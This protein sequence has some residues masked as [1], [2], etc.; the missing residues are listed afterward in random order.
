MPILS[1]S[2]CHEMF[3]LYT[4]TRHQRFVAHCVDIFVS[5]MIDAVPLNIK[6]LLMDTI[7][8]AGSVHD[9]SVMLPNIFGEGDVIT[10]EG[11]SW[12]IYEIIH[13][14]NAL[15]RIAT[16]IGDNIRVRPHEADENIWLC[17]EYYP[18]P[19][20]EF[21][22]REEQLDAEEPESPVIHNPEDEYDDMPPLEV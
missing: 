8:H 7:R 13:H 3:Q 18:A 17:V 22:M 14:S 5:R 19:L 12:P 4:D 16:A 9:M 1:T 20:Y 21:R 6:E 10:V 15:R 2:D 11:Q